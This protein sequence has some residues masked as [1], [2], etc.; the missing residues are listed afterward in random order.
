MYLIKSEVYLDKIN[1]C[2]KKILVISPNPTDKDPYLKS[3]TKL[4]HR[5]KLSPYQEP[6][7]CCSVENCF[8][9]FV[10]PNNICNKCA[11]LCVD[12]ISI[13]FTNLI[14]NGYTI[15]TQITEVM[16][17]SSVKIQNLICFIKKSS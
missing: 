16:Q 15:D 1:D 5:E 4:L 8:Y 14:S 11:L 6:E 9:A 10:N 7:Q 12:E 13:L 3:I 17:N 2:Y